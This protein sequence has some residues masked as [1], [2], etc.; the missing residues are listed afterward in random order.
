MPSGQGYARAVVTAAAEAATGA[1]LVFLVASATDWPR[2]LYRK[3]GFDAVGTG[4][5]FL[6][7]LS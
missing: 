6:K 2:Q 1:D 3:L 5:R 4:D 7:R